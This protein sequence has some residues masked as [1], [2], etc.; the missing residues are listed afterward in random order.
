MDNGTVSIQWHGAVR[1]NEMYKDEIE[2][3]K[4]G[5]DLELSDDYWI[6]PDVDEILLHNNPD[7][8][9]TG[10]GKNFNLVINS[11]QD[12]KEIDQ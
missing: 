11:C 9:L 2:R 5:I 12:A 7:T 8:Y 1:C 6:C 4:D 3:K 10:Y